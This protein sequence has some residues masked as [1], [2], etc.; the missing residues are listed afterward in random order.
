[1]KKN[2]NYEVTEIKY[3]RI[4]SEVERLEKENKFLKE[5]LVTL[6]NELNTIKNNLNRTEKLNCT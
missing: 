1:M 6:E 3:W 4:D 5:L 2:R